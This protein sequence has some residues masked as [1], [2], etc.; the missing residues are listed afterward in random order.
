V[1]N[2]NILLLDDEPSIHDILK[3]Y[4]EGV[5]IIYSA[6]NYNEAE[7]LLES[8]PEGFFKL[9]ICDINLTG[10]HTGLDF[11]EDHLEKCKSIVISGYLE[12]VVIDM[13]VEM[14]VFAAFKKPLMD[15]GTLFISMNSIIRCEERK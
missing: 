1:N 2:F 4:F 12:K 15:L 5:Y 11:I 9:Y 14:G 7:K 13:L 8:K 10:T 3:Q 6:Y